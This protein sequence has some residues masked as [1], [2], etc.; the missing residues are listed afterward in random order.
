MKLMV[1]GADDANVALIRTGVKRR[2]DFDRCDD[3]SYLEREVLIQ[4]T[5]V[6]MCQA[7]HL[8]RGDPICQ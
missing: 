5:L 2:V 1:C 8:P 6:T 4:I 3:V 7:A